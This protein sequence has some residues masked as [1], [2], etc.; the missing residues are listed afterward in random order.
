MSQLGCSRFNFPG[1]SHTRFGHALGVYF[2]ITFLFQTNKAVSQE[3]NCCDQELIAISGLLHDLGHGP[4]SHAFERL[5]DP[6]GN[7]SFSHT[8]LTVAL[9]KDEKTKVHQVLRKFGVGVDDVVSLLMKKHS[10]SRPLLQKYATLISGQF[11]YDRLDY[12]LRDSY[13]A[14]VDY[15]YVD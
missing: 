10:S 4:F 1:A 14:G 13:F 8:T 9:I 15:G 12:L 5:E 2:L 11:D 6:D 7:C 3:I